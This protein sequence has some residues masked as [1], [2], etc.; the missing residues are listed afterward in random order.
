MSLPLVSVIIPLYNAENYI[1]ETINSVIGQSWKN[2]EI[3]V[4]DDGSTDHSLSVAKTFES[5]S[6][7][8]F[9]QDNKGASAARN[10][11]LR[12]AKGE[13]IQFI[14]ADDLISSNKIEAQLKLLKHHPGHVCSCSTV[15]FF[16][17]EDIA[18]P[19]IIPPLHKD[20]TSFPVNFLIDL[21]GAGSG[22]MATLH[23]WLTPRIVIDK[24][25]SWNE[26][27]SV[28]DD[29]EYFCRI[30][31]N[32]SGVVN[33]AAAINYYRKYKDKHNLSAQLSL[34]AYQSML[35]SLTLKHTHLLKTNADKGLINDIFG[36]MYGRMGIAAYPQYRDLSKIAIG[37][38]KACGLQS[39]RYYSGPVSTVIGRIFGWRIIRILTYVRYKL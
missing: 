18:I 5:A 14:D 23:S 4:I 28:D 22:G 39:L 2:L 6:I 29:G 12:E 15:Y 38:A 24:S 16:D 11:G 25:G 35:R 31:L 10:K 7:K 33:C 20:T 21:Y 26:E 27:L 36:S 37:K 3:L 17:A 32:S 9:H 8:V 19:D 30:I 34:K 1:A 13:Y